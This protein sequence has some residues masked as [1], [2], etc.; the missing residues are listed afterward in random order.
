MPSKNNISG[1]DS[2]ASAFV[3]IADSAVRMQN[4][5]NATKILRPYC[6]EGGQG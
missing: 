4:T 2:I 6:E 1:E 3:L 5:A